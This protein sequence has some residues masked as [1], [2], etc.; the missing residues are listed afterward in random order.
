M[1]QSHDLKSAAPIGASQLDRLSTFMITVSVSAVISAANL[2]GQVRVFFSSLSRPSI[3]MQ[4]KRV[5]GRK[6]AFHHAFDHGAS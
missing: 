1:S 5:G 2:T 6:T 4:V 3:I